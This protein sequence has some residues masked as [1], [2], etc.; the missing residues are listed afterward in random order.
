MSSLKKLKSVHKTLP[1][2][3][4]SEIIPASVRRTVKPRSEGMTMLLDRSLGPHS[5]EEMIQFLGSYVDQVKLSFG[6]AAL[7]EPQ[8]LINKIELLRQNQ[9]DVFPGGTLFEIAYLNSAVSAFF[10]KVKHLGFNCVEISDGSLDIPSQKKSDCIKQALDF[11]FKVIS[12]VGKKNP[13]DQ[14]PPALMAKQIESDLA[15]GAEFVVVE[16]RESG[17]S[18]GIYDKEGKLQPELLN[19]IVEKIE[20]PEKLIWEAPLKCQQV[21]LIMHFGPNVNLGN[22]APDDLL[23]LEGL[24][25]GLR[26]DTI[27][28]L[29]KNKK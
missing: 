4:W 21:D 7:I 24:R 28:L 10:K 18:V 29:Q 6:T 25:E 22:I 15:A 3:D 9:I 17:K 27:D 5:T 2:D 13:A 14:P 12:E 23:G 8:L 20:H 16:A 26:Y 11:G 19:E 1:I